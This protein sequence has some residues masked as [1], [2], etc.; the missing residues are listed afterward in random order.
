MGCFC[1]VSSKNRQDLYPAYVI[2]GTHYTWDTY[3]KRWIT[4]TTS[5]SNAHTFR[6]Y[7][8][9][10][11]STH[12][13][14]PYDHG[15]SV[16]IWHAEDG[17]GEVKGSGV[18]TDGGVRKYE[19]GFICPS[20]WS[21]VTGVTLSDLAL[22][23]S[24]S[25]SLNSL[26]N[27][28]QYG[29][30]AW[31]KYAPGQSIADLGVFVAELKDVPRMLSSSAKFFLDGWKSAGSKKL[32]NQW[33]N[34]QF[35]WLPFLSDLRKF[36]YAS[37]N[38]DRMITHIRRNNGVW[39]KCG[40]PVHSD[41]KTTRIGS[42]SYTRHYPTLVSTFYSN[43]SVS[44]SS[45]TDLVET[46]RVWTV[47][48]YRY[49]IPDIATP[50]W[51]GFAKLSLLGARVDPS[52]V[53]ELT[54]FSWLVDWITNVEDNLNNLDHGWAKNLVSQGCYVMRESE[55]RWSVT[56]T[57]ALKNGSITNTWDH[58]VRCKSRAVASPFGFGLTGDI[59]AR[60]GSILAALGIS[61][62]T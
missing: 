57:H 36:H 45:Y 42:T 19:G 33:L 52:L 27:A 54:P 3:W 4:G 46:T 34:T 5:K 8:R 50:N 20:L 59:S 56:S 26:G 37:Q 55:K 60:Q 62:L 17:G 40:G 31:G 12:R 23:G 30:Q 16:N 58:T 9:L 29:P 61:R 38:L 11:G 44:G 48:R 22:M 47:G 35:G 25:F 53:W 15:L 43:P 28:E 14:P 2:C 24:S 13:G 18:Y 1:A 39:R 6:S 7:D 51:E 41:E 32:A 49:Y 21:T 10:R